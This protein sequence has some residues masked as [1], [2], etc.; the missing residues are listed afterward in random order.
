MKKTLVSIRKRKTA[1]KAR[2]HGAFQ[3]G[4]RIIRRVL[5]HKFIQAVSRY[6]FNRRMALASGIVVAGYIVCTAIVRPVYAQRV[7]SG[8]RDY[9]VTKAGF[10]FLN[11]ATSDF[12]FYRE[13]ENY[14]AYAGDKPTNGGHRMRLSVN[15]YIL[16]FQ[17]LDVRK[18]TAPSPSSVSPTLQPTSADPV[19]AGIES[20]INRMQ[21]V[22]KQSGEL[23]RMLEEIQ[24]SQ[25][26]IAATARIEETETERL[27]VFENVREAVDVQY[28]LNEGGIKEEILLRHPDHRYHTFIYTFDAHGLIA[29]DVG[30]LVWYF[31]DSHGTSIFRIPKGYAKDASG[32]FTNDVRIRILDGYIITTVNEQWLSSEE[33]VFPITIDPSIEVIPEKRQARYPDTD[34]F[35]DVAGVSDEQADEAVVPT[36]LPAVSV[37]ESSPAPTT[38]LPSPQEV[39]ATSSGKPS[40]A[41]GSPEPTTQ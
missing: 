35:S 28:R 23:D 18:Y 17:L 32:A 6:M 39:Y 13:T 4:M 30:N 2:K 3:S 7:V 10:V 8:I 37:S 36:V 15:K 12:M 41:T 29:E 5:Q 19:R 34:V 25:Q 20:I 11:D 31:K 27:I 1:R 16:D 9:L 40:E 22:E 38:V 24:K 33:R 21:S 14:T 26:G